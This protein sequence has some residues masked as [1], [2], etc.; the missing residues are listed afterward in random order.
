MVPFYGQGMNCGFEDVRV[1]SH[2]LDQYLPV[3]KELKQ[4]QP[5]ILPYT[6]NLPS[7]SESSSSLEDSNRTSGLERAFKAY[8]IQRSPS[9]RAIQRLAM[10]NY[11]EM[12][13]HVTSPTYLLRK[14]LDGFLERTWMKEQGS[15]RSGWNSLYEMVT[16]RDDLSYEEALMRDEWQDGVIRWSLWGVG[17][18]MLLIGWKVWKRS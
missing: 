12:S 2:F 13:S 3:P 17:V 7:S 9:L 15:E 5:S 11:D 6:S 4:T 10:R 14:K 18:T 16:F 1:L 8:S